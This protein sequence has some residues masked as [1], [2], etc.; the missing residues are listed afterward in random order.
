MNVGEFFSGNISSNDIDFIAVDL[1]AGQT[2]TISMVGVGGLS[3]GLTDTYLNLYSSD[4]VTQVD[5]D[6]DGPGTMSSMTYMASST[7]TYYISARAY[8]GFDTGNYMISLAEGSVA[9]YDYQ[10]GAGALIRPEVSWSSTSGTSATI[11]YAFRGTG[12]AQGADGNV[13][14]FSQLTST[15]MEA[16]QEGLDFFS[17]V[18][19][20]TFNQINPGGTSESATI[21]FGGYTST[22]DGSG[23]Y[24]YYPGLTSST[25]NAGD[26]WFNNTHVSGSSLAYGSYSYFTVLHELGHAMG[27]AHPGDYNAAPGVN[28]TYASHAQYAQDSHQFTVMSYFDESNTTN[29][30]GAYPQTLMVHDIYAL[31][32]L[33]GANYSTR[34]GDTVYGFNS[35]AGGVYN[36]ATNSTP[37]I[38]IWDGAGNDTLDLSGF[39]NTQYIGLVEGMF[40]SVGGLT[41]NL[42]IAYGAQIENAIGGSGQDTIV[43]NDLANNLNGGSGNDR[44]DGGGGNDRIIFDSTDDTTYVTGGSG[45]DTLVIIGGSAPTSYNLIAGSFEVAEHQQTDPGSNFWSTIVDYYNSSWQQ[46]Y[47]TGVADDGRTWTTTFDVGNSFWYASITNWYQ[48]ASGTLQQT[49]IQVGDG[50]YI[51]QSHDWDNS[52]WWQTYSSH[53]NTSGQNYATE[54]I[55]DNGSYWVAA[56]D[57]NN[58]EWWSYYTAWYDDANAATRQLI[59]IQGI[60]DDG[61]SW[62]TTYDV[63]DIYSWTD[64]TVW[65]DSGGNITDIITV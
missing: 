61:R 35:N 59:N 13:A 11:T 57:V 42:S 43:G 21:L 55:A 6:D 49:I 4:G 31:H 38:S 46:N 28:I 18:A 24:A 27:L 22:T 52:Q 60:A 34:A 44:I 14:P 8:S 65:F 63:D 62:T 29:S 7:G 40:S 36:F 48:S 37:I 56:F 26:V 53:F 16:A 3:D 1:I 54:G 9:Q 45:T 41:D 39:S 33:Y 2:Y 15:Q 32:Q 17:E 50:S 10:M 19:G 47:Q 12:P 51:A 64:Q 5:F 58:T 23:A 25:A 20:L 30:W